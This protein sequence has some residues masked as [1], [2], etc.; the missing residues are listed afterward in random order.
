MPAAALSGGTKAIIVS[1]STD[2][3]IVSQPTVVDVGAIEL[4]PQELDRRA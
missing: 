2:L 3:L 4:Y 1:R